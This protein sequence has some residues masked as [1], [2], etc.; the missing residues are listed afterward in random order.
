MPP[1]SLVALPF[2]MMQS[3]IVGV[4][5]TIRTPEFT[6][7]SIIQ[8]ASSQPDFAALAPKLMTA[9]LPDSGSIG[10]ATR[11]KDVIAIGPGLGDKP[12]LV[13]LTRL[14]VEKSEL[15]MVIDADG[16]NALARSW[17]ERCRVLRG[18][19]SPRLGP[20]APTRP[21][22]WPWKRVSVWF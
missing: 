4:V 2:S 9:P 11:G 5:F 14:L 17:S 1:P 3:E 16:L 12:E 6:D 18:N 7:R 15:P 21:V 10:E 13:S 8:W 19:P 22:R 20:T